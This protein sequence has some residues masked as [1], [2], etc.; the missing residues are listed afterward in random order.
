MPVEVGRCGGPV[1]QSPPGPLRLR[2]TPSARSA[3]TSANYTGPRLHGNPQPRNLTDPT[4][5]GPVRGLCLGVGACAG[6]W[7]DDVFVNRSAVPAGQSGAPSF[8]L[9]ALVAWVRK[10]VPDGSLIAHPA[11][12]ERAVSREVPQVDEPLLLTL[13]EGFVGGWETSKFCG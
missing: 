5:T 4:L 12:P 1:R 6:T 8:L 7:E 9:D 10:H 11:T 13:A 3:N 2:H